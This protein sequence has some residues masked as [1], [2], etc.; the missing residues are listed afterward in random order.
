MKS[1]FKKITTLLL[2]CALIVPVAHNV[3]SLKGAGKTKFTYLIAGLDDAAS[4]TDVLMLISLD[5]A[6]GAASVIQIPRDTYADFGGKINKINH[7]YPTEILGES[8]PR[9]AM[10][11]TTDFVADMLGVQIDGFLS[12]TTSAFRDFVD[13]IGGV[14]INM[15]DDLEFYEGGRKV[16]LKKGEN[17]LDAD[18]SLAFVR[19]R[20]SYPTGDLGRINAQKIFLDGVYYSITKRAGYDT[21]FTMIS[22]LGDGVV[23]NVSILDVLIMVLKRSSKFK[24]IAVTYLTLPGEAVEKGGIWYYVPN[25]L[26]TLH[27]LNSHMGYEVDF[28]R[29][30]RLVDLNDKAMSNVYYKNHF[31]YPEYIKNEVNYIVV[32]NS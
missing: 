30:K 22:R 14:L 10:E 21:L 15:P 3:V 25:R 23:T 32:Q 8:T 27:A 17:L 2:S 19:H 1:V 26:A 6:R 28:D 12:V 24:D 29:E 9:A 31:R 11:R 13:S 5:S 20:K 7:L 4:N 18:T 16:S